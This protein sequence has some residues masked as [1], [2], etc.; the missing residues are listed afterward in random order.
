MPDPTWAPPWWHRP[1]GIGVDGDDVKIVQRKL[2]L[3]DHGVY[4]AL[5]ES[6]VRGFQRARELE[7][8]G[9]VD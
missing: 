7:P 5:V 2:G 3:R 6:K 1:I 9:V 4:D 8:T